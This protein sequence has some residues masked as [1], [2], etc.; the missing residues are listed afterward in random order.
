MV[1][2]AIF[3]IY[4]SIIAYPI[5]DLQSIEIYIGAT[6]LVGRYEAKW[7]VLQLR[8]YHTALCFAISSRIAGTISVGTSMTV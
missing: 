2:D 5:N 7:R 4:A 1:I 3:L 8:R 6:K